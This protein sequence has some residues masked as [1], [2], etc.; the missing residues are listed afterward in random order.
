MDSVDQQVLHSA[1]AWKRAGHRVTL[2]TV[3]ETWGSAPR[4]PG[5]LLA[6]RED[7]QI[8]G[9]VSG[10]C[11]EDDLID[12]QRK[13]PHGKDV[14][15]FGGTHPELISYG[16]STEEAARFGLPCGGALKLLQEPVLEATW[17]ESLLDKAA[18]HELALRTVEIATGKVS[19]GSATRADVLELTATHLKVVHG[20]RW[21]LLIIGAGQLS[22]Y[23]AEMAQALDYQVSVCDPREEYANDWSVPNTTLLR[24]MPDDTVLTLQPD[25][26]TA[27]V[28]VTHD[29]KLDDMALMEALK[30]PAFYVGALGSRVNTAK[31]KE[32]LKEFDLA[33]SEIDK[34]HGPIGLRIGSRTP[35]EIAISILA[36]ITAVKNQFPLNRVNDKAAS[37]FTTAQTESA[38]VVR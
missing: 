7:G 4:P 19:I 8:S 32:R 12:R 13:T 17:L 2:V 14:V 10:G 31:R 35:P 9:S 33:Q 15:H 18:R 16:V 3:V 30:S 20:P 29:P 5:A 1:L 22:R 36:E 23:L 11:V 38:C 26:H 21:R 25:A 37:N 27:V 34:L 24:T 6:I 28:A